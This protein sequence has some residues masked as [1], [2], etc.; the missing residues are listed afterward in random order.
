MQGLIRGPRNHNLSQRQ[1]LSPIEP[2]RRPIVSTFNMCALLYC[3]C[4]SWRFLPFS[5]VSCV[6]LPHVCFL[7]Y[8]FCFRQCCFSFPMSYDYFLFLYKYDMHNNEDIRW[9]FP[10]LHTVRNFSMDS[11]VLEGYFLI[12]PLRSFVSCPRSWP[13]TTYHI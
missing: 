9:N 13:Q 5:L 1:R 4:I 2:P 3:N 8:N 7:W 11:V 10:H 6:S 12:F